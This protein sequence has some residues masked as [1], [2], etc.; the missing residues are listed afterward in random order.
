MVKAKTVL[1]NKFWVLVDGTE[2]I[3]EINASD[4]GYEVHVNGQKINF[5]TIS[6]LQAKVGIDFEEL[7]PTKK[8]SNELMVLGFP[9]REVPY[10]S[11]WDVQQK[12]PIYSKEDNS[13]SWYAAGWYLIKIHNNWEQSFCPKLISIQR[14]E[15]Y[16][17]YKTEA[18]LLKVCE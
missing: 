3:G 6:M 8:I 5:K 4:A 15:Y 9:S 17:P 12:A 16:G 7:P 18:E 1:K 13:K 11:V 2:R 10:N 14:H